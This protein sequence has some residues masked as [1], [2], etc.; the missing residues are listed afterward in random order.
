MVLS[1][2]AGAA[3]T[4]VIDIVVTAQIGA[5]TRAATKEARI[6]VEVEGGYTMVFS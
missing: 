4:G 5:G 6:V 3:A 2:T 1:L